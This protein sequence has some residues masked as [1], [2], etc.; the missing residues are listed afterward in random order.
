M[1]SNIAV[2]MPRKLLEEKNTLLQKEYTKMMDSLWMIM[3]TGEMTWVEKYEQHELEYQSLLADKNFKEQLE[4]LKNISHHGL[5]NE[6]EHRQI[7]VIDR[8][9]EEYRIAA[10]L[11]SQISDLWNKLH[12]HISTFRAKYHNSHLSDS[13]IRYRLSTST[14]SETSERVWRSAMELG[15]QIEPGLIEL[16]QLRNKAARKNGFDNYYELKMYSQ[17]LNTGFILQQIKKLRSNLDGTYRSIKSN[18]DDQLASHFSV[19]V[20][21]LRSWHYPDPF[22]QSFSYPDS[23]LETINHKKIFKSLQDFFQIRDFDINPLMNRG[24]YEKREKKSQ[25][26]FCLH[27]DRDGDI[28]VSCQLGNDITSL[29]T[30]LHE[31][32]HAFF[33]KKIGTHMP[34]VLRQPA[35]T[36][37]TEGIALLFERLTYDEKW[38][39]VMNLNMT[40]IEPAILKKNYLSNLLIKLYWTMTFVEFERQLYE[41]PYRNLNGLWWDIVEEIQGITRPTDW[42]YPYWATKAH[43]TTLPAYYHNYLFGELLASQIQSTLSRLNGQWYSILGF[44]YLAQKICYPGI[45]KNWKDLIMEFCDSPLDSS[46]LIREF[47]GSLGDS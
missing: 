7:G 31:L 39:K 2:N 10:D 32:G 24:D 37:V 5:L 44:S 9:A 29:S 28:R 15:G 20:E 30:L 12:Y 1:M 18:I 47:S 46:Y 35:H 26:N 38:L 13:D 33:E 27:V 21:M 25:A 3:T 45:S 40:S 43:F 23:K 11:R 22:F 6:L 14:N 17:E 8:E 34:F 16:V 41:N 36:L 42:D 4:S 19:S